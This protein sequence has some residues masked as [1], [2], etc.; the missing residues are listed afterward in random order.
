MVM[1]DSKDKIHRGL[2]HAKKGGEIKAPKTRKKLII[3]GIALFIVLFLIFGLGLGTIVIM[4]IYA[5]IAEATLHGKER[6]KRRRQT[7]QQVKTCKKTKYDAECAACP[8][9]AIKSGRDYCNEKKM[10]LE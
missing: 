8:A 3:I 4:L 5:I 2:R 6:Q 1:S 7:T 10:W 9:Y